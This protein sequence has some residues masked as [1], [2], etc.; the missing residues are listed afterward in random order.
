MPRAPP[1]LS[2]RFRLDGHRALL[3]G[4]AGGIGEAI[5]RTFSEAGASLALVD[6]DAVRLR[7]LARSLSTA[8]P[9]PI[10]APADV[11]RVAEVA[12]AVRTAAAGLGGLDILVNAAGVTA[13]G[14]VA[15]TD[16]AAWRALLDINLTGTFLVC[17]EAV[18]HLRR[19][20]DAAVVTISSVYSLIGG[21]DRAA[22]SASKGGLDA[23]TR[24]MAADLAPDGIRVNA[25]NPG[26]IRTPMTAPTLRDPKAMRFFRAATLLP[27]LGD[28]QDV[29]DAV[30]YLVSPASRFVTG[31]CLALD[32]GR[33][34]GR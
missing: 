14:S 30:L 19:S 22:Y 31:I 21:R 16:P 12:R 23:L 15:T 9:A 25:V 6:R 11:T 26:F 33:A 4:A 32:G 27:R 24:S 20:K 34:L 29:A 17:H 7:A 3:T 8:G 18:P 28:P 2:A 1:P 5:A 10:V 13:K